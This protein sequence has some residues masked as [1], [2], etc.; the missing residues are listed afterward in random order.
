MKLKKV[1]CLCGVIGI[2]LGS[3]SINVYA[4]NDIKVTAVQDVHSTQEQEE[5][6]K[7]ISIIESVKSQNPELTEKELQDKIET[8]LQ[9]ERG[10]FDI[11]NVLT[12][13]EKN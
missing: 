10:I 2:G 6:K 8:A 12:D 1:V 5:F 13:S 4:A 11:W 7:I 3:A 9:K